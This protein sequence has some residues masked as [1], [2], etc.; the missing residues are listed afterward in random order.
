VRVEGGKLFVVLVA[1]C[2]PSCLRKSTTNDKVGVETDYQKT[3][4]KV[5][6]FFSFLF[7]VLEKRGS[8]E[9]WMMWIRKT[10]Y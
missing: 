2:N 10:C 7:D 3:Y 1:M 5:N 8:V 6:W 9:K 4:H